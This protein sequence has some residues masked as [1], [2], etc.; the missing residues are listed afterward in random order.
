MKKML[1]VLIVLLPLTA[2]DWIW[3]PIGYKYNEG[4]LPG[5]PVNLSDFNT[6]YDDY[7]STAPSLGR[8]IPFCFSTNR[9]SQGGQ[10]DVIYEPMNVHFD[11]NSG[12]LTVTNE[13][14]N[15]SSRLD[16]YKVI[17]NALTRIRSNSNELGPNLVV[18]HTRDGY[19]FTLLYAT[20]SSGNFDICFT[21][22]LD[23]PG[24]SEAEPVGFLNSAHNDLYPALNPERD[25]IYFC[26]DRENGDFDIYYAD[27]PDPEDGLDHILSGSLSHSVQK[28]TVLSGSGEDKCPFILGDV[29]VFA[30]DREGGLGGFDLYY[31]I[32]E[33]G[34]WSIPFNFGPGINTA[35]DEYRPILIDEQV[36]EDEIMM[37]F[38]SDRQGG[39]GGFDLWFAGISPEPQHI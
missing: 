38:S 26:S 20:D 13:Y 1:T 12:E 30:S 5:Q 23:H 9:N 4:D 29:L 2:C 8:L 6:E 27:L 11:K 16:D 3:S 35:A 33:D 34:R 7:N 24:F 36:T 17:K 10:F 37:V 22:N 14:A 18:D 28:D 21:S 15:W 31:S 19:G 39:K 25:R 32:R